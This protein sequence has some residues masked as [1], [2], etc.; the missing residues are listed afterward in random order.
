LPPARRSVQ[1]LKSLAYACRN[2]RGE[3]NLS[4]ALRVPLLASGNRQSLAEFAPY[5]KALCKLSEMQ[6]VDEIPANASAPM[7]IVGETKLMLQVAI[8]LAAEGERLDKEI[9]RLR[10]EIDKARS[11]LANESFVAR[12]PGSGGRAGK[13]RLEAFIATLD[14]L[15]PQ[16]ERLRRG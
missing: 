13:A 8:D 12:A 11:K 5:L 9:T 16:R 10:N 1:Q 3:M 7:A 15:E 4:P 6:I 14:K 2:L